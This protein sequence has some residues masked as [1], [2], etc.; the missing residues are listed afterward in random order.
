MEGEFQGPPT[1]LL[2]MPNVHSFIIIVIME[3]VF[4]ER[5]MCK[6]KMQKIKIIMNPFVLEIGRFKGSQTENSKILNSS[7]FKASPNFFQEPRPFRTVMLRCLYSF[8]AFFSSS[9]T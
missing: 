3:K 6:A 2:C 7:S 5:D 4:K 8:T 1:K 9:E